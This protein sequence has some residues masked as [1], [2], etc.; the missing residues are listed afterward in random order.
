MGSSSRSW[1][2]YTLH[3]PRKPSAI[4]YV[5]VTHGTP[6][7]R[8]AGHLNNAKKA[9]YH[10]ERWVLS[11]LVVGVRP[12]V[13][14]IDSGVGES[15][16]STETFWIARYKELGHD[17]TNHAQGGQGPIGCVRT[18]ETKEK[19]AAANR[20][21]KQSLDLVER[22]IAPLRGRKHTLEAR[23]RMSAGAQGRRVSTQGIKSIQA[24][25]SNNPD[26]NA[27]ISAS[28]KKTWDSKVATGAVTLNGRSRPSPKTSKRLSV[29]TKAKMSK[30]RQGKVQTIETKEKRRSQMLRIWAERKASRAEAL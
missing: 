16:G 26:W 30:S 3:D 2:I 1:V 9:R 5:G 12:T 24:A 10:S 14:V 6:E 19:L 29:A 11:L 21:K 13:T 4:R 8:L 22:R 15:W 23:N 25:R 17:L 20:G 27:K 18:S 7:R 28:N